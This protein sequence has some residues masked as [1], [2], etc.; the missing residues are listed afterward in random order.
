MDFIWDYVLD[1]SAPRPRKS[2]W[3]VCYR[4]AQWI[5]RLAICL[6]FVPVFASR[7]AFG[8]REVASGFDKEFASNDTGKG[9]SDT[10]G[11]EDCG[12][13]TAARGRRG[14][15]IDYVDPPRFVGDLLL[16][17]LNPLSL[18]IGGTL[19]ARFGVLGARGLVSNLHEGEGARLSPEDDVTRLQMDLAHALLPVSGGGN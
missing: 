11:S 13:A 7:V 19:R 5:L 17:A 16:G 6:D 10:G 4:A 12:A 18:G 8:N 9:K 2:R 3:A 14:G 1:H 15:I